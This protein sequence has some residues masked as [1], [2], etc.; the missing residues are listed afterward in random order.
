[1]AT[2]IKPSQVQSAK[3][4]KIPDAVID[5]FNQLIIENWD[6]SSATIKQSQAVSRILETMKI[7]RHKI[8]NDNLLDVESLFRKAGW[9]VDF[10]RPGYNETYEGFWVFAKK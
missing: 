10:D 8:F 4:A 3:N 9:I 2:P 6:G 1:M 5:A 7:P